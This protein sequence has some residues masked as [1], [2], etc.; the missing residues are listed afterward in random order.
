MKKKEAKWAEGA[1]LLNPDESLDP[2]GAQAR[3]PAL[4][5]GNATDT[6]PSAEPPEPVCDD[7]R[8][9]L[10]AA[11]RKEAREA[12]EAALLSQEEFLDPDGAQVPTTDRPWS[13]EACPQPP[14]D[15]G[16]AEKGN[17]H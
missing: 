9:W 15:D 3:D 7:L 4:V 1:S 14:P 5:Q 11:K 2:D 6:V 16:D 13:V 10:D 8:M 17:E 12:G